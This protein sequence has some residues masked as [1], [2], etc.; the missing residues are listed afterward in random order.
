MDFCGGKE[1]IHRP[2]VYDTETSPPKL[3]LVPAFKDQMT[4]GLELFRESAV[5][6]VL[7]HYCRYT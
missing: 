7:S 2:R 1:L 4:Y 3:H 5:T 6:E